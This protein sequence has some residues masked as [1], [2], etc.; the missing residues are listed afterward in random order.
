MPEMHVRQ[1]I[2][3]EAATRAMV[4][5]ADSPSRNRTGV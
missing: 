3:A 2:A 5:M 1:T 4:F